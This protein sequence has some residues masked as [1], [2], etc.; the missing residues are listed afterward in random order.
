[1]DTSWDWQTKLQ[2][3]TSASSGIDILPLLN[4]VSS[5]PGQVRNEKFKMKFI[6][7]SVW[8]SL[9]RA[10]CFFCSE[11]VLYG[12]LGINKLK[13][14]MAD[15]QHWA[16]YNWKLK[17]NGGK[18]SDYANTIPCTV[19]QFSQCCGSGMFIPDPNYFSSRAAK[20]C[21]FC[22]MRHFLFLLSLWI[23]F[24][25]LCRY[26]RILPGG[27]DPPLSLSSSSSCYRISNIWKIINFIDM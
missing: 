6:F 8:F 20:I 13:F 14:L 3:A 22:E 26:L 16:G 11:D 17:N 10:Q 15:P 21:L 12:N 2:I 24:L 25:L 1:M 23:N 7:Q 19:L 9:L 5:A 4:C 27:T 18:N